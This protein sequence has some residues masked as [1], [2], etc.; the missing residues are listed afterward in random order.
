MPVKA[1]QPIG[2]VESTLILKERLM[3]NIG[4][5]LSILLLCL[6]MSGV[7][8]SEKDI[9]G[10]D[11]PLFNRL[12]DHFITQYEEQD[13]GSHIFRDDKSREVSVE[14]RYF[15]FI[16]E[17]KEGPKALSPLQIRRN[18]E[19][20]IKKIGGTV[21]LSSDEHSYM[22][23]AREGKEIW[24]EVTAGKSIS[25]DGTMRYNP[26]LVIVER[27]AMKQDIVANA[28]AFSNDIRQTGRAAVYG[29]YFDTDKSAIKPESDAALGEIATLLKK[30]SG[31]K[32][33][34]VGHT[35]N[36]GNIDSNMK[37]SQARATAVVNALTG[38]YG[39]AAS[40]LKA[41]GVASLAP[42]ASNDTD[43]GKAKNRRVDLV[44][45]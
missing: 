10:R 11:H 42:V 33:N 24:V 23:L 31:L 34:I 16:Y 41:Y 7:A 17:Q 8:S 4:A 12:P 21:L 20:A 35:D 2:Q 3:K 25:G 29:I 32:V 27:Q 26:K 18:Y 30:D 9:G 13:F 1:R 39:I 6:L 19:N 40:R 28:A 22:K 37:L 38:R 36:V 44:K 14:G 43:E 15:F 45:Q 5:L